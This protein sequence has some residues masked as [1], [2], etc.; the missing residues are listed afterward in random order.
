MDTPRTQC[1]PVDRAEQEEKEGRREAPLRSRPQ[2]ALRSG[3]V[4][5]GAE[6]ASGLKE[7]LPAQG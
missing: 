6:V 3:A 4:V 7:L 1:S 2:Q 5:F